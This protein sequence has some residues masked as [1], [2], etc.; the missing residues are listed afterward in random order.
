MSDLTTLLSKLNDNATTIAD[1]LTAIRNAIA[2]KTTMDGEEISALA[3]YIN[4]L[5]DTS[6]ANAENTDILAGQTAYVNGAKVTGNIPNY[7]DD[8]TITPSRFGTTI[9]TANKF[10]TSNLVTEQSLDFQASNIREDITIFGTKGTLPGSHA[11]TWGAGDLVNSSFHSASYIYRFQDFVVGYLRVQNLG[12]HNGFSKV[13]SIWYSSDRPAGD[14][15]NNFIWT[16]DNGFATLTINGNHVSVKVDI[17][18][19][20]RI[21]MY[22]NGSITSSV[23]ILRVYFCYKKK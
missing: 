2:G 14:N 11:G 7:T 6:D 18:S 23:S 12:G 15:D 1:G 8:T 10:L 20:G 4:L 22:Y 17:H 3:G 13:A 5:T 16:S 19:D 21:R 9:Y